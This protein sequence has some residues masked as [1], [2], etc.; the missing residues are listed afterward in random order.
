MRTYGC[1]LRL[2][3]ILAAPLLLTGAPTSARAADSANALLARGLSSYEKG[4]YEG[5]ATAFEEVL[6]QGYDDPTVHYDLGNACFKQGQLGRAIWHYR[7]AHALAPR[8]A[9]VQANLEYARFLA[10]DKIEGDGQT[11]DRRVEGW[12]DRITAREAFRLAA[13]LWA[14]AGLAGVAWQLSPRG[15]AA[16]R[17]AA[18]TGLVLWGVVFLGAAYRQH[19]AGSVHE[20][21]VLAGE[22]TVRNAPGPDFPTAFLLHEGAEVVVEG[23]R[24]EWTEIS[25]PGDLR[26]WIE[27][28][29]IALL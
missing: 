10:L 1:A 2:A 9:D 12:L 20:A 18:V 17:R 28:T 5:A 21:I 26:G 13:A 6:A 14:L 4:D 15:G 16:W 25:L 29:K 24:G 8:D 3:A 19:R 7:R 27:T 11:T 22:A 23:S